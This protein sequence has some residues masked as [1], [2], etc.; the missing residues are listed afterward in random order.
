MIMKK[1][2]MRNCIKESA[3][4]IFLSVNVFLFFRTK[5]ET[6]INESCMPTHQIMESK[7]ILAMYAFSN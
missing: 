2:P 7:N 6:I 3:K 1:D 5:L 4:S